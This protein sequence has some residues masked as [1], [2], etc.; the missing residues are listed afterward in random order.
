MG[1]GLGFFYHGLGP[2]SSIVVIPNP[3]VFTY[4]CYIWFFAEKKTAIF[5]G[6]KHPFQGSK[7]HTFKFHT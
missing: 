3:M 6:R 1:L 4:N 5:G 2:L 7:A